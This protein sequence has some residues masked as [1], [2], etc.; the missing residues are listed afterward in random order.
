LIAAIS[1]FLLDFLKLKRAFSIGVEFAR[2]GSRLPV[3]SGQAAPASK[4]N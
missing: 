1:C 3:K 4:K 2:F